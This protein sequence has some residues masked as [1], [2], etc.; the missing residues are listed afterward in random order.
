MPYA[1]QQAVD[2]EYDRLER[3]GIVKKVEFSEWATPWYICPKLTVPPV[4]VVIMPSQITP[5]NVSK[6]PN[7][8]TKGR[9]PQ[10][11]GW[12]EIHEVASQKCF[13]TATP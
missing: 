4:P 13:S 8:L 11:K 1:L 2:E 12:S 7:F 5:V 9:V 3:D 10:I 6:L